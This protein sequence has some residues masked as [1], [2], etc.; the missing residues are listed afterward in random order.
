[1]GWKTKNQDQ[2]RFWLWW[3]FSLIRNALKKFKSKT[4]DDLNRTWSSKRRWRWS[5]LSTLH[6]FYFWKIKLDAHISKMAVKGSRSFIHMVPVFNKNRTM[7]ECMLVYFHQFSRPSPR[8]LLWSEF[9]SPSSRGF[10]NKA[11]NRA[12]ASGRV[13]SWGFGLR[14][15]GGSLSERSFLRLWSEMK[16][17]PCAPFR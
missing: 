4:P 14:L 3:I 2:A 13:S 11:S 9:F 17:R 6:F 10:C 15:S 1:M 8:N 16:R 5:Q 12:D 7:L